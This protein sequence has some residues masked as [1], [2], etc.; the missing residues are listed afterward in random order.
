MFKLSAKGIGTHPNW[1]YHLREFDSLDD[2]LD[3]TLVSADKR[4]T[5]HAT[6]RGRFHTT[7]SFPEAWGLA[8]DGW[9][10]ARERVD[11]I[12]EAVREH[13]Q[14]IV[15][16]RPIEVHDIIGFEPDIDR[17]VQGEV[18]CMWDE[19]STQLPGNGKVFTLLVDTCF[20]GGEGAK[21]ILK[22]GAAIVSLVEAFQLFGF[23]LDIW[24]E[25]TVSKGSEAVTALV[26]LVRAGE[27]CDIT[28][29]MFPLAHPD[30]LRRLMF[31][32][33]EGEPDDH[34]QRF[35]FGAPFGSG[36]GTVTGVHMS[37]RVNAS[38]T[39]ALSNLYGAEADPVRWVVDQL[40]AQGVVPDDGE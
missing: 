29:A 30:W 36:Y 32:V 21:A 24:V 17:Y 8:R 10:A 14:S 20:A 37:E 33:F 23:E 9:H 6:D 13:V 26:H 7:G 34:R 40:I 35:G 2:L 38:A 25:T 39:M 28:G 27:P 3:Y 15:Q 11:V 16:L 12:V 5:S 22:R 4:S 31:A 19:V 1:M 18:E